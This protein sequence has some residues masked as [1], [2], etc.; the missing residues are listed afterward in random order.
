MN[1]TT[2]LDSRSS[3]SSLALPKMLIVANR[4]TANTV[5]CQIRVYRG[6]ALRRRVAA[7]FTLIELL[8]V[9]AI[10]A[11]L[12]AMLL[13]A[14][15]KAKSKAVQAHCASNLKQW[16]VAL[17]MYA[18]DNRD[19]FPDN[20]GGSGFAWM[21]PNLNTNFYP[22]YLYPNRHGQRWRRHRYGERYS[23]SA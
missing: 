5:R 10:I 17:M 2:N 20:T 4:N 9:I 8:V 21:G 11:I 19:F 23:D 18:G 15:A 14:L 22:A 13:P 7:A 6:E 16:G 12:A 1:M 3:E